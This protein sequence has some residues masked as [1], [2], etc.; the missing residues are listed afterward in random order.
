MKRKMVSIREMCHMGIFVAIIAI[1]AQLAIPL[2]GGVPLTMQTWAITLAGLLL[3]AKNGALA[4]L[5]YVLLGIVGAPVFSNFGGGLGIVLGPS[6][7]FILS[8]PIMALL[9]GIGESKRS[10]AWLIGSLIGGTLVNFLAGMIYFGAVMSSSLQVSFA[11]A[12]A[13]FIPSAVIRIILLPVISK[14]IKAALLRSKV[15]V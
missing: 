5:V 12:V 9:A 14:G 6:G 15:A 11:A 4:T 1:C 8:F 10:I 7:G 3:G 13:P 2:P